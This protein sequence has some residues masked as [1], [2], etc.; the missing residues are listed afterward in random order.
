MTYLKTTTVFPGRRLVDDDKRFRDVRPVIFKLVDTN[1]ST[2]ARLFDHL[3]FG[4]PKIAKH[5]A[6]RTIPV[7]D[8]IEF[9]PSRS[10][11]V[12]EE[13]ADT[14][15]SAGSSSIPWMNMSPCAFEYSRFGRPLLN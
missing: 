10:L 6:N 9:S 11:L 1:S 4:D 14:G 3:Q 5:P 8:T 15:V 7:V 13:W 12:L 2:E